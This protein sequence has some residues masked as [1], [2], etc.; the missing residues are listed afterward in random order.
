MA[1]HSAGSYTN[2]V[3]LLVLRT[4]M[5]AQSSDG[6]GRYCLMHADKSTR[7]RLELFRISFFS[8]A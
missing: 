7:D 2:G 5:A 4:C 8:T 6:V 1:N 3:G